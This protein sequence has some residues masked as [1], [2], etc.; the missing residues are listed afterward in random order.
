[1]SRW[2]IPPDVGNTSLWV[3]NTV[4]RGRRRRKKWEGEERNLAR[5]KNNPPPCA[6]TFHVSMEGAQPSTVSQHTKHLDF[7]RLQKFRFPHFSSATLAQWVSRQPLAPWPECSGLGLN[8]TYGP[9]LCVFALCLLCFRSIF[10]ANLSSKGKNPPTRSHKRFRRRQTYEQH[11]PKSDH[12]PRFVDGA[13]QFLLELPHVAYAGIV[14]G[15]CFLVL[16]FAARSRLLSLHHLKRPRKKTPEAKPLVQDGIFGLCC[17]YILTLCVAWLS[18]SCQAES[19]CRVSSSSSLSSARA[20][21]SLAARRISTD[22]WNSWVA[23]CAS[24]W[25]WSSGKDKQR[26]ELIK[27]D[28]KP[29]V[30]PKNTIQEVNITA[31]ISHISDVKQLTACSIFSLIEYLCLAHWSK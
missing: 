8:L 1:M 26:S 7:I 31:N 19:N 23:F 20:M 15:C 22:R 17:I 29:N 27:S 16:C 18:I 12:K 4:C 10:T 13:F 30:P 6:V 28:W 5:W 14:V 11:F 2:Y 9:F 25:A 24:I 21:V 3:Q